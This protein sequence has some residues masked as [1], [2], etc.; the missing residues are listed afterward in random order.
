MRNPG[1]QEKI[2]PA[3]SLPGFLVSSS[4]R[5]DFAVS[6]FRGFAFS[7]SRSFGRRPSP[8]SSRAV[9]LSA[10]LACS[11]LLRDPQ[12]PAEAAVGNVG[13]ERSP[14]SAGHSSEGAVAGG[15]EAVEA[16]ERRG[17]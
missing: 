2:V 6:P 4:I 13:A 11:E 5:P 12:R 17:G 15:Q 3:V 16:P 10:R 8:V 14:V 1:D 7:N 9:T